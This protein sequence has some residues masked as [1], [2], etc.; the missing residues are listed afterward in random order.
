MFNS[1][2]LTCIGT[3]VCS[4]QEARDR[5][6][7]RWKPNMTE[8]LDRKGKLA[9]SLISFAYVI[10]IYYYIALILYL[11]TANAVAVGLNLLAQNPVVQ[12]KVRKE[13]DSIDTNGAFTLED[14]KSMSYIKAFTKEVLR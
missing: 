6:Q 10:C 11:Q 5:R 7:S 3:P 9:D 12:E 4:L 2:T 13:V 1:E 14:V 8:S